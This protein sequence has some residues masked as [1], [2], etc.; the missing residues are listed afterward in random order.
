VADQLPTMV[1]FPQDPTSDI[2]AALLLE[3][4]TMQPAASVAAYFADPIAL[5]IMPS[6]TVANGGVDLLMCCMCP[7]AMAWAPYFLDFKTPFQAYTMGQALMTTLADA[8]ER[9]QVEPMVDWLRTCTQRL[10]PQAGNRSLSV[11]NQDFEPI[12]P[13][14][15]VITW[16]K[17]RLDHFRLPY[18]PLLQGGG[19][20]PGVPQVP[21]PPPVAAATN[22]EYTPLEVDTILAACG[23]SD[24]EWETNL[25]PMYPMIL[26]HHRKTA[27]IR[28]VLQALFQEQGTSTLEAVTIYVTDNMVKD[29]KELNFGFSGDMTYAMCHR[30]LSPFTVADISMQ[31]ASQRQRLAERLRRVTYISSTDVHEGDTSPDPLPT[32]YYGLVQFLKT[33]IVLLKVTAGPKCS[34]MWWPRTSPTL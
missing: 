26:E 2:L 11:L 25:P 10:G 5:D 31:T 1:S 9:A 8:A 22:A 3:N 7:I 34:H 6:V 21:M 19:P 28:Q 29:I 33:Y 23:L 32:I 30:G 15:R 17:K 4:V 12:A 20:V 18:V 16:M 13:G 14:P 24:A 27:G